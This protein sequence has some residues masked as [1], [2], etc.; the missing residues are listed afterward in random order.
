MILRATIAVLASALALVGCSR[1]PP[2]TLGFTQQ[3]FFVHH[4]AAGVYGQLEARM[5]NC[6]ATNSLFDRAR[7]DGHFD[8]TEKHGRIVI[9]RDGRVLWGA[10]LLG[11]DDGT[12]VLAYAARDT[13]ADHYEWLIHQ[14]ADQ[15]YKATLF[16]DC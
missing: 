11:Q 8:P 6:R 15:T 7:I 2:P 1:P 12:R 10:E 3:E 9:E 16:P 4:P 14:W 5:T 13:K